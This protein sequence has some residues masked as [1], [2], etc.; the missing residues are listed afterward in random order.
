M[1]DR[2][3]CINMYVWGNDITERTKRIVIDRL[4]SGGCVAI[5]GGDEESFLN[6]NKYNTMVWDHCEPIPKKKTRLMTNSEVRGF[7]ANTKGIEI[8]RNTWGKTLWS[9]PEGITTNICPK[10]WQYRTISL[11]GE[12]GEPQKFEVE[13]E[14]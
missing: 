10:Y 11:T 14:E 12:V 8:R 6:H 2:S 9:L 7:I 13:V 1:L 4:N 3:K 5:E